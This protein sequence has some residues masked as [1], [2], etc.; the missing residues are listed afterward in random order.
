VIRLIETLRTRI[1]ALAWLKPAFWWYLALRGAVVLLLITLSPFTH[2]GLLNKLTR[3]DSEWYLA[4]AMH[5]Y[6]SHL[7]VVAGHVVANPIAFFPLLPMLIRGLHVISFLPYSICGLVVSFTSGLTAVIAVGLLVTRFRPQADALRAAILFCLFPGTFVF[8]MVYAEGL[9]ITLTALSLAAAL[10]RRWIKAG[11][12]AAL[13]TLASPA[14]I[15]LCVALGVSALIAMQRERD[16]RSLF[17]PLL[18]PLG[19]LGYLGYLQLHTESWEA[20]RR[21]EEGG[22]HSYPSLRYPLHILDVFFSNPLRAYKTIDLL[23]IGMVFVGLGLWWAFRQHQPAVVLAYAVA[24]VILI[25]ISRPVGV[26]PRFIMLAFPVVIAWAL[27]FEGSRFRILQWTSVGAW[28]ILTAFE[29]YSW[30]IFP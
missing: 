5:G 6:P 24:S 27:H 22:W 23:I 12:L 18:S 21:T 15:A 29:F 14:A 3:W 30:A 13:A 20:W 10:D 8:S 25:T 1:A 26:R 28:G 11:L 16:W 17:A 4:A 2:E 19:A 7:E 9:I